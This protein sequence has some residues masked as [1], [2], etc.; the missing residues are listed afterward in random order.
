M[1]TPNALAVA[2]FNAAAGGYTGQI[3]NDPG[4]LANAAGL[5]LQRDISTDA[6]YVEHLLT[7]FGVTTSNPIYL[8]AKNALTDLVQTQGRG[9]AAVVAIDFLKMQE[10][11]ANPYALV[12]LNFAVKVS[13]ATIYSSYNPNERDITKLVSGVTGVDTDQLAISEALAAVNPAFSA[14]LQAALAAADA[15]AQADK[16]TAVAVQKALADALAKTAAD[17]AAADLKAAQ[18]KAIADAAAAKATLDKVVADNAAALKAAADLAAE[19]AIKAAADKA[20]AAAGVDRTLDNA[21]A[22][23]A[24]LKATAATLGLTGYE[25]MS[26]LQVLNLIKYSDNQAIAAAVDKSTDNP[27]AITSFLKSTAIDLGISGTASMSNSQLI[28]AIKTVNDTAIAAAQKITDDAVAKTAADKAIADA[29]ALKVITDAAAAQAVIDRTNAVASQ[30]ATDD[31]TAASLKVVTDAAAVKAAADLQTALTQIQTLQNVSGRTQALS[32]DNDT[33]LAVSGGNDTVTATN[34]TYGTD[35]LVVDTSLI[36]LDVLVLSTADDISATPVVVGMENIN[37]NVTSVYG[38]DTGPT[39]LSFNADNLRNSRLN[40]DVTNVSSVVTGLVLTNLPNGVAVTSSNEFTS[41][42]VTADDNAVVNY[43]G[44][45]TSLTLESSGTLTDVNVTLNATTAG[46]ISTDSD[47]IVTITTAGDTT[48]TASAAS[49]VVATSAAQATLVVNAADR[50]TVTST[51]EALVTANSAEV[52][53]FVTGDG[54]DTTSASVIASSLSST[55]ANTITVNVAGRSSATVVDISGAANVNTVNV[56]GTQNVTLKLSL[57]GVDGLGTATT[58]TTADDNLLVV[59]NANSGTTTLWVQ[60]SGGDADFSQANVNSIVLGTGMGPSDDLTIATNALIVTAA[61]QANDLDIIAKNSGSA[62]NTVRITVQDNATAGVDGDLAGGLKLTT[63]ATATLTNNDANAQA[64]LGAVNASGTALT[65]AAGTQGFAESS[66]IN[67]GTADL[68]ITGSGSVDLGSAVTAGSV[69]GSSAQGSI[70]IGLTGLDTVGTVT[71]G[72]GNDVLSI[73]SAV[74]NSSGVY[75]LVTGAGADALTLSIVQDFSWSAG[76]D[77]DSLKIVGALDL[78][79]KTVSL[80]SVDEIYLDSTAL[81][82]RTFTISSTTFN[83]NNVF[84]LRG[85]AAVSDTMIVQGLSTAD[86]I[87]ASNVAVEVNY[88]TLKINGA[89]GNDIITGTSAADI[90]DG[91]LGNDQLSGGS[92][93]D[94]YLYNT[95][96]VDAGETIVES[97]TGI[98][99]DTVSVVTTTDFRNMTTSSFDEIEAIAIASGQTAKYYGLQ[100]TGESIVLTGDSGVETVEVYVEAGEQFVSGLSNAAANID[101]IYYYGNT[102]AETITGGAMTEV[103]T[104][105]AGSDLL[106]G[107]A[108]ADTYIFDLAATNGIDRISFGVVDGSSIDDKLD[109]QLDDFLGTTTEQIGLIT[110]S[111]VTSALTSNLSGDNILILKNAYFTDAAALVAAT[112]LFAA[113]FNADGKV[114]IIYAESATTDTRIAVATINDAG[115]VTAA[116]DVAVLVGLTATEAYN[117]FSASNFIF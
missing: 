93:G 107:G 104:G 73:S 82:A 3:A 31:A 112:T 114:L 53:T 44:Y 11:A 116:T 62:T 91:G 72:L 61:D 109:F 85:S 27:T 106:A 115:D 1:A 12:A 95:G 25:S 10:A 66:T 63:F 87:N 21:T 47:A 16:A 26:D 28:T 98:G 77:Y 70:T 83:T 54:I 7:N 99:T 23:T 79:S 97:S 43:T 55:N 110:E 64:G 13:S 81:G 103:I 69:L 113:S 76:A 65:I 36:D 32:T 45:A 14:S 51:E 68:S 100:L 29:A 40:F 46:T 8:E 88:A 57:V 52:V 101:A 105:G 84:N 34:L 6:L 15:K 59:S 56:T 96:D 111:S 39:V 22:I 94:T 35:D 17:K 74:R 18:D 42:S 80:S 24:Y 60:T 33:I 49:T 48:L 4:S 92:Y 86:T 30:K 50:V 5:I 9:Q 108:G 37:V 102:G 89:A 58:G 90:I 19:A 117:G 38:G 78:T 75:T 71:T 41:A 67:L 2:L 20:A